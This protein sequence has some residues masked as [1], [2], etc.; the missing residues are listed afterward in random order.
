MEEHTAILELSFE[1]L[2]HSLRVTFALLIVLDYL[3][4]LGNAS[5]EWAE[6]ALVVHSGFVHVIQDLL[7]GTSQILASDPYYPART[8]CEGRE[9]DS[10][11]GGPTHPHRCNLRISRWTLLCLPDS[12]EEQR[13]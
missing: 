4:E 13:K 6:I 2:D 9:R 5:V 12:H 8:G 3:A 11:D 10:S 7:Y 1:Q